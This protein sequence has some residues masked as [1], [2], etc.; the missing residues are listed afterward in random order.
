MPELKKLVRAML[1]VASTNLRLACGA[2]MHGKR[3][4]FN[5]IT[6]LALSDSIEVSKAGSLHFGKGF[7]TRGR[8]MFNVQDGG[9]LSFGNDV[10]MNSGCQFN[11]RS[12]I[13][14]GDGCEFGP[15]VLVYDHDHDFRGGVLKDGN[16]LCSDV[17]IGRNCWIGAGCI[18]LRGTTVGDC[19]TVAAGSIIKG[20]Y[21]ASSLVLQRRETEVRDV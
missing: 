17:R 21:P 12:R 13:E 5:P 7:R 19:C 1:R 4:A 15:N 14:V 2:V 20:N 3:I 6:C 16:F 10:F 18:I 8:C 9:V 11:C